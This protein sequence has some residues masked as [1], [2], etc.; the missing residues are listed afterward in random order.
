MTASHVV[1]SPKWTI[2]VRG[3][4]VVL[5]V[6]ILGMSAYGIYWVAFGAFILSLITSLGTFIIVG[7]S[8]ATSRIASL[9]SAYNYWAVLA[10]DILAAIFW[11][12]SM[13]D[14]AATRTSFKYPTTIN[15]CVNYG[16]GGICYRKR[17][18]EKRAVATYGYLD[19]MSACAGLSALNMSV[20]PT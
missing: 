13:A 20:F 2:I 11:L 7:Y 10:L 12:A 16:Y 5:A 8:V 6:A 15:G 17:D 14:L 3:L 18:L 1:D 4:Q 19:M 9:H